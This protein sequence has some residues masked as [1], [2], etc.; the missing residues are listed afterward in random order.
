MIESTAIQ[1]LSLSRIDS[2]ING[3]L[4]EVDYEE[5]NKVS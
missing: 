4:G 5:M 3:C 2:L 1:C